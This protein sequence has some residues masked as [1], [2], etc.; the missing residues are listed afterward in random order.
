[1]KKLSFLSLVA[2][3]AIVLSI[4][5]TTL[6]AEGMKCG[7]GKCGQ[8][9]KEMM[10]NGKCGQEKKEMMQNGKCGEGKKEM[11]QNGKYGEEKKEMMQNGKS[12]TN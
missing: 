2:A 4:G 11:M 6:N 9:K 12:G 5:A 8:A 7:S 10:Q 1:M 3:G